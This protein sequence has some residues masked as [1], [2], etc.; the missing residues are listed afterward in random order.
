MIYLRLLV[1]CH[2]KKRHESAK[3]LSSPLRPQPFKI[4]TQKDDSSRGEP[5]VEYVR[6]VT[7]II[8]RR[9]LKTYLDVSDIQVIDMGAHTRLKLNENA[10]VN[11]EHSVGTIGK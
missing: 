1:A 9:L 5:E 8:I 6:P 3:D 4:C 7:S 11:P 2:A 10:V